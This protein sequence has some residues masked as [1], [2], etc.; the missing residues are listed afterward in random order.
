MKKLDYEWL[1]L[2]TQAKELGIT[3]EEVKEF[4]NNHLKK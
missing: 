1:Q 4:L 3:I 2:I